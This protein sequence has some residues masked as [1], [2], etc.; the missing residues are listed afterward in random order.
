MRPAYTQEEDRKVNGEEQYRSQQVA[1]A[2][3]RRTNPGHDRQQRKPENRVANSGDR[4]KQRHFQPFNGA[5]VFAFLLHGDQQAHQ[6]PHQIRVSVDKFQM[7]L[8]R[9]A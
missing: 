7:I 6:E 1:L 3:K 5:A 8:H 2:G 9:R 4:T